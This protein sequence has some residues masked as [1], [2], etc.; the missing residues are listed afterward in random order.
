[1]RK[2]AAIRTRIITAGILIACFLMTL[3]VPAPAA[4]AVVDYSW[5]KVKL[6]TNNATSLTLYASGSYFIAENGVAFSNGTLTI[7]ASG[8]ALSVS[9]STAGEL[10][11]G[12]SCS[13]KRANVDRNAGSLS[14]NGRKYLGHFNLKCTGSGYIQVVNEVPMA[15]YLYGVVGYEMSDLSFGIE[16]LK[17]QAIAA[18]GYVMSQFSS[19]EYYIGDT[20]SDQ[21]Y[22]GYSAS[23][24]N[25]MAAVDST[26]N[27][28]LV[29]NGAV[30]RTYF[31]ASNGGETNMPTYAWPGQGRSD[32]GYGLALDPYDLKNGMSPCET[33]KIPINMGGSISTALYNFIVA[34]A[35][36]S[37][38]TT[39]TAIEGIYA[40][41]TSGQ[42]YA[43]TT[44]NQTQGSMTV[45]VRDA[46]G[47]LVQTTFN[48]RLSELYASGVVGN[49]SLRIY[50]GEPVQN[51][52]YYYIYHLRYGH[53]VGLSQRGAQQRAAEGQSYSQILSFYYPGAQLTATNAISEP[54]NPVNALS[55]TVIAPPAIG[56][57]EPVQPV[58]TPA[59]GGVIAFGMINYDDTNYRTGPGTNYSSYGKL[60]TGV[61]LEIYGE[62]NGWYLVGVGGTQAYVSKQYVDITGYPAAGGGTAGG[63]TTGGMTGGTAGGTA[64]GAA[65]TPIA[66]GTLTTSSVNYR[67]GP[68]TS[69]SSMGKFHKGDVVRIYG[70]ENDWYYVEIQNTFG[71]VSSRYVSVSKLDASPAA[72]TVPNVTA[73]VTANPAATVRTGMLTTSNVNFRSEPSQSSTSLRKL[74]KN[75][76]VSVLGESG[77]WYHVLIGSQYGYVYKTY[78]K[79]T[80]TA[81]A[82]GGTANSGAAAGGAGSGVTTGSVNMRK[83]PATS[84]AKITSLKKGTALTV[85]GEQDGWYNA[86]T[87]DGK[88]GYVSGK[89]VQ[90]TAAYTAGG[91]GTG[92]GTGLVFAEPVPAASAAGYPVYGETTGKVNFREGPSTS[93]KKLAQLPKGTQ[94][95][96]Y[97]LSNGWFEVAYS[98]LRGYVSAEYI[99]VGA[100]VNTTP[101]APIAGA[102]P[103]QTGVTQTTVTAQGAVKPAIGVTSGRVN[104]RTRPDTANSAVIQT[105]DKGASVQLLG[106]CGEWY[107]ALYGGK[108]GFISGAYVTVREAG[109]FGMPTVADGT[110]AYTT[111]TNSEVNFR[112]GPGTQYDIIRELA[113]NTSLTVYI[114]AEGWCL[115]SV[116]GEFGFVSAEYV[117]LR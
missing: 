48:F 4:R 117:K 24:T 110:A 21:V 67:T 97:G 103:P 55:G 93:T 87:A 73:P 40:V 45:G 42:A 111:A 102:V 35:G 34:K 9:H 23:Y 81:A 12:R 3:A 82:A 37:L 53:G 100:A 22:K 33:V 38:G 85:Y 75:T 90:I 106:K 7:R 61:A 109:T 101:A 57:A 88:S 1:M 20:S 17:A 99:K 32:G 86:Q 71:Y 59:A 83:G 62:S 10:Y 46:M 92:G 64:G 19:G 68:S 2:A 5:V 116:G 13:I 104:F 52:T 112:K 56:A 70:Q 51:G 44:R 47:A 69:Y 105:F 94:V 113:G 41:S 43:G 96:L 89:Y 79:I 107:Y 31:A 14:L 26:L 25:V 8:S 115:V 74:A 11:S 6:T 15:H 95:T 49:A 72:G 60:D 29:Y 36:A 28:I 65:P 27:Q 39:V 63:G 77:D 16:A 54:Q 66:L 50:W 80:G 98:F 18:K 108:T 30:M 58:G 76:A 84:Y 91:T 114:L 78:I